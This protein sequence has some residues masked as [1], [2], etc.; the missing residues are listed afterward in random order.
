LYR[1][2]GAVQ[3]QKAGQ[4]VVA[5]VLAVEVKPEKFGG[6]VENDQQEAA[7]GQKQNQ[8]ILLHQRRQTGE[9]VDRAGLGAGPV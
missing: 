8:G 9:G 3:A 5:Q 7:A 2:P 6:G 4:G 1:R